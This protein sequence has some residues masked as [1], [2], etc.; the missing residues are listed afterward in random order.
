[1]GKHHI[2]RYNTLEGEADMKICE[3]CAK[4]MEKGGVNEEAFRKEVQ[5]TNREIDREEDY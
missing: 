4:Y 3:L 2:L 5:E 1:M